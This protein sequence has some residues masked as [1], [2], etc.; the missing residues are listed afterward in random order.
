MFFLSD[1]HILEVPVYVS[2]VICNPNT[3][4]SRPTEKEDM[5]LTRLLVTNAVLVLAG[6]YTRME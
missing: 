2:I 6:P 3:D 5:Q 4:Q 1:G